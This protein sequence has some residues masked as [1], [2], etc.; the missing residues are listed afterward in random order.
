MISC[1]ES[2][3]NGYSELER[4][5]DMKNMKLEQKCCVVMCNLITKVTSF[6]LQMINTST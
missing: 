6:K 2:E 3:N 1:K 4:K 5:E